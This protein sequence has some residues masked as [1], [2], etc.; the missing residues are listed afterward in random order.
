MRADGSSKFGPNNHWGYFPAAAFAWRISDEPFLADKNWLDNL[1][2]RISYGT[3]GNDNID[4][5]LW[6]ETYT[7]GTG[8]WDEKTVQTF[9]PSGLKE[10]PDLKWETSISRNIGLDFGFFNRLNGS[11][12]LYWNTTKDLL[13]RQTIDSS[14]GYSYQYTNIGQTSNKG[15][16]LALNAALV[17]SKD[18]NLNL[19]LTY[20]LNFNNVDELQDHADIQ[21]GSNWGSSALM[22][23]ND[24]ILTEGRP[25]GLVRGYTSAGFYT[26][27]DFNY[28]NGVYVLKDGVADISSSIF[29]A[30]P[31]P[32]ELKTADGQVAFPGCIKLAD[33]D[34]NGVVNTDDVSIIG[35]IQPHHTGGFG[36]SGNWKAFDFAA[37]FT[38]QIGGNVYNASAMCEY[39]GGKEPGIGKNRRDW[40]SDCFKL[41]DI[42]NGEL[43]A[44]TDP[45]ALAA[46]N[47]GAKYPLPYY[48]SSIV[49]SEFVE[50]A[51]FLRLSNLTIGYTLPKSLTQK[52][53]IQSAR[54]YVT[55]GNLFCLTGYSGIDPEVNTEP[56]RG[57]SGYPTIGLDYG[58]YTRARTFTI[59]LNVKF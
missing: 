31:R 2:L 19:N 5:S 20:N 28:V 11:L 4:S 16:E 17:R 33:I 56:S 18:F 12:E 26:V 35:E 15:L 52:A 1:K 10:N 57:S 13:M 22:P 44:V 41:Y 32:S 25:V 55:G 7:A 40:L 45:T 49:L 37:N 30:Y 47:S 29:T 51:S 24:Y 39:S 43:V 46:L 34:G 42:Q 58:A 36:L 8:V 14:T 59:G 53:Y 50:D 48:E 54:I 3:S 9:A 23:G 38:Y 6:R 21:Y 27:D